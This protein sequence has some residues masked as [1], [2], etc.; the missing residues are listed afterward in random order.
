M[1]N[2]IF[3]NKQ[4]IYLL[5]LIRPHIIIINNQENKSQK[6]QVRKHKTTNNITTTKVNRK[7]QLRRFIQQTLHPQA[8]TTGK[9]FII[10][11][12]GFMGV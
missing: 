1:N 2:A 11:C 6:T 10:F 3:L 7:C 5:F 8:V 12:D 9:L 4:Y